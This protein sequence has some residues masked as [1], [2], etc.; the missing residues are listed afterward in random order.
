M[1]ETNEIERLRAKRAELEA[2]LRFLKDTKNNL[3]NQVSVLEERI[4]IEELESEN[5]A[6]QNTVIQ[7][8]SKMTQLEN[9]L[10]AI[11]QTQDSFTPQKETPRKVAATPLPKT[12]ET[13]ETDKPASDESQEEIIVVEGIDSES[14]FEEQEEAAE[15]TEKQQEKKKRKF[16]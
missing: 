10:K 1:S 2:E 9:R 16:F 5:K 8:Q 14:L 13:H 3:E 12:A 4:I 6:K 7:L 11:S 15:N